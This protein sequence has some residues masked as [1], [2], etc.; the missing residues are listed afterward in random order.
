MK[1]KKIV[2]AF[3]FFLASYIVYGTFIKQLRFLPDHLKESIVNLEGSARKI[4]IPSRFV[5]A[6]N[7]GVVKDEDGF[8][9]VFRAEC[10][11]L[12]DYLFKHLTFNRTKKLGLCRLDH[13]FNVVSTP[14]YLKESAP[15]EKKSKQSPNDPRLV[16]FRGKY[17]A[18]YND[19]YF[20][21]EEN[22]FVRQ[23]YMCEVMQDGF[24]AAKR[25]TFPLR[26]EFTE[27]GQKF[28]HIEKNWSPFVF[29]DQ[30]Y[31][32]YLIEPHVVIHLDVESGQC[33]LVSECDYQKVWDFGIARGGTPCIKLGDQYLSLFHSP[34]KGFCL[35]HSHPNVY[36]MGAYAFS[37]TPPFEIKGMTKKPIANE[38]FFKG[39]RKLIF[40][41]ALIDQGD[42]LLIF[43]GRDD[44]EMWVFK[45]PKDKLLNEM[46]YP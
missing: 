2:L 26:E 24:G 18:F 16:A 34:C 22:G 28:R 37:S 39:I 19:R 40:P 21:A 12:F 5:I 4:H 20:S 43:Y 44:K 38:T 45:T 6:T 10:T 42:D 13:E 25:L 8:L 27:K 29:E 32:V 7:P 9:L 36:I 23:L 46:T 1:R 11:S 15:G 31:L 17:Y 35:G 3:T 33:E 14:I 30:L 41:T